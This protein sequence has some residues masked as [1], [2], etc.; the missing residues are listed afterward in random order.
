MPGITLWLWDD[1]PIPNL[2]LAICILPREE[3]RSDPVAGAIEMVNAFQLWA[4]SEDAKQIILDD[5]S[6][7][8]SLSLDDRDGVCRKQI[9]L[10]RGRCV[11]ADRFPEFESQ[12]EEATFDDRVVLNFQRWTN[13]SD[14]NRRAV[15]LAELPD[16]DEPDAYIVPEAAPAHVLEIA[17]RFHQQDGINCLST[18]SYALTE[19][20]SLFCTWM[21]QPVFRKVLKNTGYA[22]TAESLII[23][24][25]V[26]AFHDEQDIVHAAY[27][28]TPDRF[29]NKNGQSSFNPVKVIDLET[30]RAEWV[31]YSKVIY[32]GLNDRGIQA[33]AHGSCSSQS[34]STG[35]R[36]QGDGPAM[37]TR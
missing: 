20:D 37:T 36:G 12:M 25:D 2:H 32:R 8:D 11:P 16:W 33:L 23:S 6:W 19:D 1:A 3:L 9:A 34:D 18:V 30:L 4:I 31:D 14:A 10:N 17:N 15:V 26:V 7:L 27:A 5:G 24:G 29:L 22:P 13:T 35:T 21:D 28:L